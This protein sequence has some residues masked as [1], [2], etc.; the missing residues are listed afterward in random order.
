MRHNLRHSQRMSVYSWYCRWPTKYIIQRAKK[1]HNPSEQTK[2]EDCRKVRDAIDRRGHG[3]MI[4]CFRD[5]FFFKSS[6]F[7]IPRKDFTRPRYVFRE[8]GFVGELPSRVSHQNMTCVWRRWNIRLSHMSIKNIRD[9][10]PSCFW[11]FDGAAI[12]CHHIIDRSTTVKCAISK[13]IQGIQDEY[14]MMILLTR[15]SHM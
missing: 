12:G 13:S 11:G 10:F 9:K 15:Q 7:F 3:W 8:P 2:I 1:R 14:S 4:H 6:I 5:D